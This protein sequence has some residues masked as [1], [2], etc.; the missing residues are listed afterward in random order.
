VLPRERGR[1]SFA[2]NLYAEQT[3]A[4]PTVF[5]NDAGRTLPLSAAVANSVR[6]RSYKGCSR[7]ARAWTAQADDAS[8]QGDPQGQSRTARLKRR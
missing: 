4:G 6:I 8:V 2:P 7:A 5:C 3:E 1:N